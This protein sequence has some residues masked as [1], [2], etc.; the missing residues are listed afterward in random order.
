MRK[1]DLVTALAVIFGAAF[2]GALATPA[3]ILQQNKNLPTSNH[4]STAPSYSSGQL[5][6]LPNFREIRGS[7]TEAE[8]KGDYGPEAISSEGLV[9]IPGAP[10]TAGQLVAL[11]GLEESSA[12]SE[13]ATSSTTVESSAA[14]TSYSTTLGIT[15]DAGADIS[16]SA[17]VLETSKITAASSSSSSSVLVG[18][19]QS[20][21]VVPTAT[22]TTSSIIINAGA[23]ETS[24]APVVAFNSASIQSFRII[25]AGTATAIRS[26]VFAN[27][28]T[29][30]FVASTHGAISTSRFG[31]F[32][33]TTAT[34]VATGAVAINTDLPPGSV[35]TELV[36][37]PAS[38]AVTSGSLQYLLGSEGTETAGVQQSLSEATSELR[39]L[40][41]VQTTLG[42]LAPI[43]SGFANP[44]AATS[45]I[46]TNNTLPSFSLSAAAVPKAGAIT[47]MLVVGVTDILA[48][49]FM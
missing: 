4:P 21:R 29:S 8:V 5:Q 49:L 24:S 35:P 9:Q 31:G 26:P 43:S 18:S 3:P 40:P 46:S 41:S 19:F 11:P 34:A 25:S 37:L 38:G 27:V 17:A 12:T 7:D 6:Q 15:T 22:T 20:F 14:G 16:S 36:A 47:A 28:S 13:T 30:A 10:V 45:S 2:N 23:L 48:V 33:N 1:L 32:S 44:T 42:S 39:D